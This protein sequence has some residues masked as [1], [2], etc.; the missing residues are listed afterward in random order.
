[1]VH[2]Y[3]SDAINDG[4]AAITF[5]IVRHDPVHDHQA[6]ELAESY[7]GRANIA[8]LSSPQQMHFDS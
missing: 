8:N 6:V 5:W 7:L 1:M 2:T 3:K 4:K